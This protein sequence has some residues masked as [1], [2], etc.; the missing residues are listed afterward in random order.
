[1][2]ELKPNDIVYYINCEGSSVHLS[3][4]IVKGF[5]IEN[6]QSGLV[7]VRSLST[8]ES[9]MHSTH[10]LFDKKETAIELLKRDIDEIAWLLQ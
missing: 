9:S 5:V 7:K 10:A 8:D 2:T 6:R 4:T 1:M 3:A